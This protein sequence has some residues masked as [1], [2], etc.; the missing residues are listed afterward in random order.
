MS[1]ISS[2]GQA[3]TGRGFSI[4][5]GTANLG[6]DLLVEKRRVIGVHLQVVHGASEHSI[7]KRG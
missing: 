4:G 6:G 2:R 3:F 5:N 7:N 1:Q